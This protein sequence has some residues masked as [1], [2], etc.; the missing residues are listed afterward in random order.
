MEKN[1]VTIMKSQRKTRHLYF[2]LTNFQITMLILL[3]LADLGLV[4]IVI[5][6]L[7]ISVREVAGYYVFICLIPTIINY[8]RMTRF[9]GS[10]KRGIPIWR[11]HLPKNIEELLRYMWQDVKNDSGFIQIDGDLRLV[12]SHSWFFWTP[13]PYVGNIDLGVQSPKIEYRAGVAG[14]LVLVPF[15]IVFSPF[16]FLMLV[17]SHFAQRAGIY[18]FIVDNAR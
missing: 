6:L 18:R 15:G 16:V 14:Y 3:A 10:M 8:Y 12:S 1:C 11:E 7:G 13:W 2:G 17:M 9:S 4:V 5:Q